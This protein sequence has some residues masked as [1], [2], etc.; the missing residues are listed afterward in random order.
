MNTATLYSCAS[1]DRVVGCR[2]LVVGA[3]AAFAISV[4]VFLGVFALGDWLG[5]NVDSL[6]LLGIV[7]ACLI[8]ALGALCLLLR[9]R[10]YRVGRVE[11]RLYPEH[12]VIDRAGCETVVPLAFVREL[13]VREA[14][15]GRACLLMLDGGAMVRLPTEVATFEM[16]SSSLMP[17][18][19]PL[20]ERRLTNSLES[21]ETI[22]ARDGVALSYGRIAGAL[23]MF[24]VIP[25]LFVLSRK[26]AIESLAYAHSVMRQGVR[27]RRGGFRISPHGL[28]PPDD[29]RVPVP[30]DRLKLLEQD[31]DGI[32]LSADNDYV[33]SASCNAR[34]F[35][36]ASGWITEKL[37]EAHD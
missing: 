31:A 35:I 11:V 24:A 5:F 27:G 37:T 26:T 19:T 18:L 10:Y 14:A 15:S 20:L 6:W 36:R 23:L 17:V 3:A 30:W 13:R 21:G 34:D 8:A 2:Y 1:T 12:I 33:L 7:A 29:S 22:D 16:I 32:V 9:R 28:I 4:L 25:L